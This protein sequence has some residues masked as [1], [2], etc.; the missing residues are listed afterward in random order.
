MINYTETPSAFF[1]R[2]FHSFTGLI[3]AIYIIFHLLTNSQAAL[4]I[5]GDGAGFIKDVNW[6]HDLPYLIFIE[7]LVILV[8]FLVHGISGIKYLWTSKY[9]NFPTDGSK[10]QLTEYP[11]NYFYM[12][13]R[14]T[15]WVILVGVI[16]HVWD[17]RIAG[18]PTDAQVGE[19]SYYINSISYDE[20]LLT[21]GQRL[22]FS[23]MTLEQLQEEEKK[24]EALKRIQN[25]TNADELL[26]NQLVEQKQ[27]FLKALK[28]K[29]PKEG[30]VIAISP[31]FGTSTLLLVRNT[32]KSPLAIGLYTGFVIATV[33]HAFNGLW[34]FLITWGVL[35]T[36]RSQRYMKWASIALMFLVGALGLSAAWLTYWVNLR[37]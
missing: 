20:G 8:P 17:M 1:W 4:Y 32:F 22:N 15:S 27:N 13:Q 12:F 31:N 5:G 36:T 3:L 6:I 35:L 37:Y 19:N 34:T 2:R 26:E 10:P 29:A 7:V 33:F 21:L 25:P 16:W 11:R 24:I 23:I 30:D 9:N 14:L 18:Y 28:A